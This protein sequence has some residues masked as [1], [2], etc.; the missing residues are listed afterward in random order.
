V[1]CDGRS[2]GAVADAPP[3][4]A[5]DIPTAPNTGKAVVRPLSAK[6]RRP[7]TR[8]ELGQHGRLPE[9]A[10]DL[11]RL[12]VDLSLALGTQLAPLAAKRATSRTPVVI[13]AAGDPD[14]PAASWCDPAGER[15][16]QVKGSESSLLLRLLTAACG[17]TPTMRGA[18]LSQPQLRVDRTKRKYRGNEMTQSRL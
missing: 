16:A 2:A 13:A 7:S 1:S 3:T 11:V 5:K 17:T 10:V 18:T 9:I 6:H 14:A 4:T 15:P 8:R 12:D